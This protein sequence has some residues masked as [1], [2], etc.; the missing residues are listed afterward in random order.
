MDPSQDPTPQEAALLADKKKKKKGQTMSLGAF[1]T[2]GSAGSGT[3]WAD[4]MDA[5][6]PSTGAAAAVASAPLPKGPAWS[7]LPTGPSSSGSTGGYS[8]G[9]TGSTRVPI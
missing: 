9:R 8:G 7:S 4:E 2:S 3:S 1:N 6:R 5:V